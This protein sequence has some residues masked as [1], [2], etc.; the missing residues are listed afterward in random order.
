V[1]RERTRRWPDP[2]PRYLEAAGEVRVRFQEVDALRVVWHGHYAVYLE[3]GRTA[4]GEQFEFS[5]LDVQRAGYVIPIIHMSFDYIAPARLGET[6][7][8]RTRLHPEAASRLTFT[9]LI[10]NA[11]GERLASART[12]QAFTDLDGNLVLTR[13]QFYV[14]FL[15]RH[16][17]KLLGP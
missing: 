17:G 11:E 4:F 9:Y 13:P 15:A 1:R 3:E 7:T 14:D 2:A 10:S 5:Y 12:V 6:L 16:E 8:L